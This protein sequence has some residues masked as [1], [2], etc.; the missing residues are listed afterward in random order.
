MK[1]MA[2]S[3]I[4]DQLWAKLVI[5]LDTT[6][7]E[8]CWLWTKA[9]KRGNGAFYD[10]MWI[11]CPNTNCFLTEPVHRV[12]YLVKAWSFSPGARLGVFSFLRS[13]TKLQP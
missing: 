13:I 6:D 9:K 2:E 11:R 1:I 12:T 4:Y 10:V 7:Q 3:T 5:G 8:H